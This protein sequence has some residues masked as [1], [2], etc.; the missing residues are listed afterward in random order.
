MSPQLYLASRSPRRSQLLAQLKLRFTVLPADIAE[1]PQPGQGADAYVR[2]MALGKAQAARRNLHD[3][4][5]VLG[6]D[7][8]VVVDGEVLGK[9]ADRARGIAMLR[10]LSGRAHDVF[11]AVSVLQDDRVETE[12]SVT[13]VEFG[14]ISAQQAEA[15]WASGEPADKAGGYAIQGLGAIFVRR[16][17][18]SYSGVMGLPLYETAR[19]L[20]R[21]GVRPIA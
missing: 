19:L 4:L 13:R 7:T 11:S 9:P 6:A 14:E 1:S 16:I 8:E 18:G 3:D 17:D 5:P 12:V 10:R 21:F 20:D 15:Y 2:A